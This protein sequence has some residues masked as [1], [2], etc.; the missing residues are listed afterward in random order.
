[1]NARVAFLAVVAAF[2]AQVHA[3]ELQVTLTG[4]ACTPVIDDPC[5]GAGHQEGPFSISYRIDTAEAQ[6]SQ[7]YFPPG[8]FLAGWS[9]TVPVTDYTETI[10][11][12]TSVGLTGIG[13]FSL[14]GGNTGIGQFS[15]GAG[16]TVAPSAPFGYGLDIGMDAPTTQQQYLA[17]SDPLEYL[18]LKYFS[19]PQRLGGDAE[20][21]YSFLIG[22]MTIV[23]VSVPTPS[24]VFL[25]I[26]GFLGLAVRHRLRCLQGR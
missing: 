13:T 22:F 14:A 23:P 25:F 5:V 3:Q 20:S 15:A 10:W 18:L 12:K 7:L 21:D 6:M 11:G 8:G 4:Q 24:P 19:T 1:M 9:A 17:Q 26:T 16:G 2:C